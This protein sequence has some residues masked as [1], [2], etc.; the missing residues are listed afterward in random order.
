M[1]SVLKAVQRNSPLQFKWN[2]LDI[3][4]PI[5]LTIREQWKHSAIAL[6]MEVNDAVEGRQV[7]QA[8][9]DFVVFYTDGFT[10]V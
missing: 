6:E 1:S 3:S 8:L 2:T 9:V 7:I 5:S 4:F 10:D